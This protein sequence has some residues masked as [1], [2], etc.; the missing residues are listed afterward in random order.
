MQFVTGTTL[1]ALCI[2]NKNE[3]S[4][5]TFRILSKKQNL[6]KIEVYSCTEMSVNSMENSIKIP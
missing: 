3:K 4:F 2:V 1:I 6:K 5:K